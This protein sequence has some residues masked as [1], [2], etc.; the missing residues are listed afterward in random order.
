MA[1]KSKSSKAPATKYLFV[2]E[3]AKSIFT[4]DLELDR[5]KQS[6]VQRTTFAQR[7][8][9]RGTRFLPW[10]GHTSLR[11]SPIA[12]PQRSPHD[13]FLI[14]ADKVVSLTQPTCLSQS[15]SNQNEIDR[16]GDDSLPPFEFTFDIDSIDSPFGME[17]VLDF[18]FPA[19][20]AELSNHDA[21]D[22]LA[23]GTTDHDSL[24]PSWLPQPN[25][26]QNMAVALNLWA[27]VLL[28]YFTKVLTPCMVYLD[29]QAA[30]LQQTRHAAAI[31]DD[32]QKCFSEPAHLY[33]LLAVTS[34]RIL[35]TEGQL[36]LPNLSQEDAPRVPIFFKTSAIKSLRQKLSSEVATMEILTGAM[37]LMATA[38]S[39]GDAAAE[40][41]HS[42][43]LLQMV[44]NLG[45]FSQ[46]DSYTAERIVHSYMLSALQTV[47]PVKIPLW[48]D[49]GASPLQHTLLHSTSSAGNS[50]LSA[51][52]GIPTLLGG[53][54]TAQI[55]ALTELVSTFTLAQTSL[56]YSPD[57]YHWLSLR[58]SAIDHRLLALDH[59]HSANQAEK[60]KKAE[61]PITT[62]QRE[63]VRL[64]LLFW[65]GAN[66]ADPIRKVFAAQKT[67]LLR[68]ALERTLRHR[69]TPASAS[70]LSISDRQTETPGLWGA[71]PHHTHPLLLWTATVGALCAMQTDEYVF[72][73][74]V[75]ARACRALGLESV[76]AYEE[77]LAGF[78]Y[79]KERQGGVV[80]T[81][82]KHFGDVLGAAAGDDG[83]SE[84]S[85]GGGA[86]RGG[87]LGGSGRGRGRGQR[88]RGRREE[89]SGTSSER[90]SLRGEEE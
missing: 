54:L 52:T 73:A 9:E 63:A 18:R 32:L 16:A 11:A 28:E 23:N 12:Q 35:Q 6:H 46:L 66:L 13:D 37:R 1:S 2:N 81:L 3:D 31:R 69:G 67:H 79:L 75:A 64:A 89:E 41:A 87:G 24:L 33:A 71:P 25:P 42:Q 90:S 59:H 86:R 61:D 49:P 22:P 84:C 62:S 58:R 43:A 27:P 39:Q 48:W 29:T 78:L 85:G 8:L 70:G 83:G 76:A 55:A 80:G 51:S 30:P 50:F 65:I 88:G 44:E 21:Y 72:F 10:S 14:T 56:P 15:S 53:A 36:I 5:T 7:K 47:R 17:D 20:P 57:L 82:F 19:V 38:R 68:A 26:F 4:K 40:D 34:A 60:E 45:G 77:V 74:R